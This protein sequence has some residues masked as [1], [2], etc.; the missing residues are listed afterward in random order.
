MKRRLL[1]VLALLLTAGQVQATPVRWVSNIRLLPKGTLPLF[2][3]VCVGGV[4][5]CSGGG[6]GSFSGGVLTAKTT[7][8]TAVD[9][10]NSIR[11]LDVAGCET[12]EGSSADASEHQLCT[13][14]PTADVTYNLQALA[15]GTYRLTAQT[16]GALTATRVPFVGANGEL[17][18]DSDLT[19][20]T[21]T[22]TATKIVGSTSITDTGLSSGRVTFAG[23]GGLLSDDSDLTFATDTLTSTKVIASTNIQIANGL[24]GTPGLFF[25]NSVTTGLYSRAGTA[26]DFTSGGTYIAEVFS[27]G[28]AVSSGLAFEWNSGGVGTAADL[29]LTREAAAVLQTGKD[30]N[31]TAVAQTIKGPD[32]ITGSNVTGGALTLAGG[33]ATGIGA[34]GNVVMQTSPAVASGTTAQVLE[35]RKLVVAKQ[36]TLVD[37]TATT[38]LVQTLGNDTGG[39]GVIHYCIY[40]ADATT[41]GIECG[42]VDFAG[43][44]V[45]SG[46]G[47][48]VCAT[49]GK[50]G[51][52]LQALSGSTLATTFAATTGTDLCNIRVTADTN[53]ATPLELWIKYSVE[54]SGR[55]LTPQ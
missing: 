30:V 50:H 43:V 8:G 2:D 4:G 40:A 44:D 24:V 9:A 21:D 26:L 39:G 6:G 23:T 51:T 16:N 33:R 22:L 17:T 3:V 35:T 10:A 38:F 54:S 34:G 28:V 55:T 13:V 37:N 47:G 36:L 14:D 7:F 45:T 12:F 46:A 52:P 29:I 15:A 27:E 5:G 20:A 53:I 31:G 49:P 42:N 18:D 1:V 32:G 48:E 11:F 25:Q 19:F 41:A